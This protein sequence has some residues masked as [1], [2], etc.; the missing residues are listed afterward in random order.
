MCASDAVDVFVEVEDDEEMGEEVVS[1]TLLLKDVLD[2]GIAG[3]MYGVVDK[4][5][6]DK[7]EIGATM[8]DEVEAIV[9]VN[10]ELAGFGFGVGGSM[11]YTPSRF[12]PPQNSVALALHVI[13]QPVRSGLLPGTGAGSTTSRPQKHSSSAISYSHWKTK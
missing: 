4:A 10:L 3:F 7:D 6:L 1:L 2:V 9:V 8:L 5:L 13:S 11:M 12:D